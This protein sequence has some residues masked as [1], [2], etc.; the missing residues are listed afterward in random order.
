MTL[1]AGTLQTIRNILLPL[2]RP[3]IVAALV[4][5]FV[6]SVTAVSAVV[7]LISP[8]Y[9]W[10]TAYIL[11]R[12]EGG[13][14]GVSIAYSSAIIVVLIVAIVIIQ[15]GVGTA[16]HERRK[17]RRESAPAVPDGAATSSVGAQV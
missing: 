15:L 9:G 10:S 17:H 12:I 14:Y 13:H 8:D 5:S 16:R 3:A 11:S 2:L 6:S 4:Y 7:F 1:G